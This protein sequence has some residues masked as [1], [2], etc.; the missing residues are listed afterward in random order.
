MAAPKKVKVY[1]LVEE[2][3]TAVNIQGVTFSKNDAVKWERV[4]KNNSDGYRGY[5][6]FFAPILKE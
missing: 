4:Q 5:Y 3:P 1:V 2:S 6:E